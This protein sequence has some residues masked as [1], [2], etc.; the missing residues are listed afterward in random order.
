MICQTKHSSLLDDREHNSS[1]DE[2]KQ[3]L[4]QKHSGLFPHG[5]CCTATGNCCCF[6]RERLSCFLLKRCALHCSSCSASLASCRSDSRR[7]ISDTTSSRTP[8]VPFQKGHHNVSFST[9]KNN[10]TDVLNNLSNKLQGRTK[11]LTLSSCSSF[12]AGS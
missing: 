3:L 11:I 8:P 6:H 4:R 1:P 7:L 10:N 9:Q 5:P 12:P 2:T